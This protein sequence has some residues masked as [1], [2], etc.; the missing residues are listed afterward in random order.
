M[1]FEN[2]GGVVGA[3]CYQSIA[4]IDPVFAADVEVEVRAFRPR[5]EPAREFEHWEVWDVVTRAV[6]WPECD[7]LISWRMSAGEG[8]AGARLDQSERAESNPK[9]SP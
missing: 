3:R 9:R 7:D 4:C 6:G 1:K 5:G 8:E 2:C